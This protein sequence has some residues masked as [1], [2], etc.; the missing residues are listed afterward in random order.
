MI[1]KLKENKMVQNG[2][3]TMRWAIKFAK[4]GLILIIIW[5]TYTTISTNME[6][7][8]EN[9]FT[10]FMGD[11][12]PS[13][14]LVKAEEQVPL[15]QNNQ[16]DNA[17]TNTNDNVDNTEV[18]GNLYEGLHNLKP[19]I[20]NDGVSEE[21]YYDGI[22]IGSKLASYMN[23]QIYLYNGVSE[24]LTLEFIL[25]DVDVNNNIYY[26]SLY[27]YENLSGFEDSLQG[28]SIEFTGDFD[29]IRIRTTSGSEVSFIEFIKII[30]E[31]T[32]L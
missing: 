11:G 5:G 3:E 31:S 22:D 16:N 25:A 21:E 14:S 28:L 26:Y 17:D 13:R 19:T 4:M 18:N 6:N 1:N 12:D 20:N 9:I 15:V 2:I 30:I 23:E 27:V 32:N 7:G 24:Y 29:N 8:A 10:A